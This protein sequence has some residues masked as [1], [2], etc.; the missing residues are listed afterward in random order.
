[1]NIIIESHIKEVRQSK[2]ISV[3]ELAALTGMSKT[4]LSDVENNHK[5]PTLHTLCH[6]AAALDVEPEKLY[7]YTKV[8][9]K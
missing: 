3:R 2:G 7:K 4:Y 1:M 8:N 6:I 5:S 9:D